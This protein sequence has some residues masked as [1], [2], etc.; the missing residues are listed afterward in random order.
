M[1]FQFNPFTKKLD[2]VGTGGGGTG[3]VTSVSV[4]S[5]NGFAGTVANP[6]TTPAITISTTQ[7]GLLSGNGTA[8]TGITGA[9][10]GVLITDNT[11]VISWLANSGTA[12]FVLTANS[13]APPSW[14]SAGGGGGITTLDGDVGSA[15]GS[16]ILVTAKGSIST[17]DC[18]STILFN[19]S[20]TTLELDVSDASA[21]TLMGQLCGNLTTTGSANTGF[22]VNV[23]NAVT[24]A[25]F[26]CGFGLSALN[27][28]TSGAANTG[29][30]AQ[31]LQVSSTSPFN[32]ACG[33]GALAQL[34]TGN[35]HNTAIGRQAGFGITTGDNNIFIGYRS[36][37]NYGSTET[38]NIIIGN[39]EVGGESGATHIG[40]NLTTTCFIAGIFGVTTSD[41]G[42]TTAVLIDNTGN[43]GTAASSGRYKENIND[44]G[45]KSSAIYK[46]RP[47]SFNYKKDQKKTPQAGLIAEEVLSVMPELVVMKDG[48][49]E[50][51]KYHD[52]PILLLT[53]IQKLRAE[54]DLLKK[55]H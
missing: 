20:G 35:G 27:A 7:T 40:T 36:G 31:A 13:G 42:S 24:N 50:T 2:I 29:I 41:V 22:G 14:Q 45:D 9:N 11:G 8:I 46:L 49:P 18:G 39:L 4:V 48:I 12:G 5:A 55:G 10:D 32:T 43:L 54:I 51:V 19:G 28:C 17:R 34:T 3:T 6:T 1:S 44:L 26:C 37:F 21:N 47:V 30:G 53:E 16:T 23:L 25:S 15:T 52:L 33:A 38:G